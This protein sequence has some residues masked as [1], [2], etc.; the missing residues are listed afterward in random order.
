M[1]AIVD[2]PRLLSTFDKRVR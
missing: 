2:D 1:R